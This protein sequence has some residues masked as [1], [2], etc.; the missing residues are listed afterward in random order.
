MARQTAIRLPDETYERLQTLAARTGR[1]ATYY[2]REAIEQHIEDLEDIYLAE[3][4]LERVRR[5]ESRV[6][7]LKEVEDELGLGD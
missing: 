6:Y 3:Q 5:G 1:T 7:S 4:E 2:I